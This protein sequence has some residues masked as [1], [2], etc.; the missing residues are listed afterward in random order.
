MMSSEPGMPGPEQKEETMC[1]PASNFQSLRSRTV[2]KAAYP[3][4][5]SCLAPALLGASGNGPRQPAVGNAAF[6]HLSQVPRFFVENR[7]QIPAPEVIAFEQGSYRLTLVEPGGLRLVFLGKELRAK[8]VEA[9][10][11]QALELARELSAAQAAWSESVVLRWVGSQP[12]TNPRLEQPLDIPIYSFGAHGTS[13]SSRA[14]ERVHYAAVCPG[15]DVVV[16]G[17]QRHLEYDWIL[18]PGADPSLA[19]V[20]IEGAKEVQ[21]TPEEE[22]EVVLPSGR[23]FRHHRPFLYQLSGAQREIVPGDFELRRGG[24]HPRFGFRVGSYDVSRPLIIDPILDFSSYVGGSQNESSNDVALDLLGN[25]YLTGL[26]LSPN[27]PVQSPFQSQYA[28]GGPD[29]FV[30]KIRGDG[31]GIAYAT[32]IGGS[33]LDI[34]L[35][36]EVNRFGQAVVAG[37]TTSSDFPVVGGFQTQPGG[38]LD[39]FVLQLSADGDELLW[40]S[41]LGGENVDLALGAAFEPLGGVTVVGQ[42]NSLNFPVVEPLQSSLVGGYDAFFARIAPGG[43]TLVFSSYWG[44]SGNDDARAVTWSKAGAIVIVGATD[45][46]NL[47]IVQA[48]QTQLG[49]EQ[50][51]YVLRFQPPFGHGAFFELPRRQRNRSALRCQCRRYR[52]HRGCGGYEQRELSHLQGATARQPGRLGRISHSVPAN[53]PNADLLNLPRGHRL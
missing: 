52:K 9:P 38:G 12:K 35:S 8:T 28:G 29:V 27:F 46:P 4:L 51:A 36:I 22:L 30:V 39:A 17:N 26:T 53:G 24:A 25:A 50:N 18:V 31:S 1:Y 20:E 44:G 10:L 15:V 33:G 47:P 34:G 45:S 16:Y 37:M 3:V 32:Y 14:F 49:G 42:T 7:G 6:T 48:F 5:L 23:S 43:S 11:P 21:I 13:H 41:Y 19:E 2:S 40:S